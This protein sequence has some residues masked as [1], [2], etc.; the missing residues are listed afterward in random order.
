MAEGGFTAVVG[1]PPWVRAE[2]LKTGD[3]DHLKHRFSWWRGSGE[4]GFRHLPD[5]S[6]A[7]TERA[8]EITRP[9]G[10]IGFLLPSKLTTAAYATRA[11]HHLSHEV[12][13]AY[14]HR[15]PDTEAAQFGATTYPL[16]LVA[17]KE[18]PGPEHLVRLSF[19]D[20]EQVAQKKLQGA[21]PWI[22]LSTNVHDALDAFLQA[23]KPLGQ[24]SPA[25]LGVKTGA[26]AIFT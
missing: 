6:I 7:F 4:T 1:N 11:R 17:K 5:L 19:S 9:G 26:N 21:G 16:V 13:L 2:R 10:A 15:L 12:S 8:L 24:V 22:L 25:V 18:K 23:G 3:R 14:L 20:N